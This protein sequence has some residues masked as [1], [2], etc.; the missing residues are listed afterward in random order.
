MKVFNKLILTFWVGLVRPS[1]STHNSS[2][3]HGVIQQK[4]A[5]L[6]NGKSSEKNDKK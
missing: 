5:I 1:Q 6:N 4:V 3:W 2:V